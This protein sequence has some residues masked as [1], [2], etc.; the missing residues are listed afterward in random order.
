MRTFEV[1]VAKNLRIFENYGCELTGKGEG[2][3]GSAKGF[4]DKGR[5]VDFWRFCANVFYGRPL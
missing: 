3:W 1:F 2:S 4:V 5:G